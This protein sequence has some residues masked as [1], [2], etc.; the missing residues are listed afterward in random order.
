MSQCS[1]ELADQPEILNSCMGAR[2]V[3]ARLY[4]AE[5]NHNLG[6]KATTSEL[7]S[8]G[9]PRERLRRNQT[10]IDAVGAAK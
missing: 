10:Q 9:R 1:S 7:A 5:E 3:T 4:L 2:G 8:H 6:C